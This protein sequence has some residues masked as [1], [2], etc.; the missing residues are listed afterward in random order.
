MR[1]YKLFLG[2][3]FIAFAIFW[4]VGDAW[5]K[6]YLDIDSPTFQQ[7]SV[8]V[9]DFTGPAGN[10]ERQDNL[11]AQLS[12]TLADY[13][14][15]TGFF[16]VINKK[17][18][19]DNPVKSDA[20]PEIIRFA[21]WT[22]IGT[23]YLVKGS[24][25]YA[26]KELSIQCGLYDVV[27]GE[28]V[29]GNKY[30]GKDEDRKKMM[31]KFARDVLFSLTGEGGVF[32]TRIAFVMKKGK[33][34]EID[35]VGFDGDDLIKETGN[36]IIFM[37]PRWSPD[38][39][40]L[41]YTSYEEGTPDFY[42]KNLQTADVKKIADF[43]GI[44]LSGGWSP[45][46][47]KVLLTLSK[48]GNEEIYA[49]DIEYGLIQRLT[50]NFDI[51]VSPAWSPEGGRIAFV[52]NRGGSPQIYIMDANGSNVKRLTF[53]GDYN[54]SPTWSP[55]GDKIAYEGMIQGRFQI[56]VIGSDG[57]SPQRL[58]FDAADSKSPTW[59]PDGRYIAFS[60]NKNGKKKIY[61]M[62]AN[63]SNPRVLYEGN[64]DCSGPS[65]S[66]RFKTD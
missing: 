7:F 15:M 52:S 20:A 18:Y 56:F 30:V 32:T 50:N 42:V 23:E 12:D 57:S 19:L 47:K 16:N 8:A 1:S 66:P 38:G 46:G 14:K 3:L 49:L 33:A 58:T 11:S 9:P 25:Q 6:V 36:N 34:A 22:A 13:L 61:I 65:W 55:K 21:D 26:G 41:S 10:K 29:I 44:N 62:N 28:L 43:P 39:K 5:G 64:G 40:Y 59:S 17:A 4:S 48:D 27:K 51:D 63:G 45:D 60:S 37:A 35:S 2:H 53:E 54:T 24:F 31:R